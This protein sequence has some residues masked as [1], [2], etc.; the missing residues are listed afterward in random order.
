[1][2]KHISLATAKEM[3][4]EK[5]YG[6]KDDLPNISKRPGGLPC[7]RVYGECGFCEMVKSSDNSDC[8]QKC[9]L[10]PDTCSVEKTDAFYWQIVDAVLKNEVDKLPGLVDEMI[11]RLEAI[12]V[13]KSKKGG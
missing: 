6:I 7:A 13:R 8:E 1:M 11:A 3:S 4:L 10:Y 2:S 9:P 12:E 5:W